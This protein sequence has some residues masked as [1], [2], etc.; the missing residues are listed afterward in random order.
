VTAPDLRVETA[1]ERFA[2]LAASLDGGIDLIEAA[3]WIAS[4]EY[5]SL[6]VARQRGRLD[7]LASTARPMLANAIHPLE[8]AQRLNSF[9]FEDQG[10]V[11]NLE[12]YDDPRNSFLNDVLE[13]RTGIPISLAAV[14]IHVAQCLDLDVRGVCFPG[15]FLVKWID[16]VRDVI[17]DPFCGEVLSEDRCQEHLAPAPRPPP[18]RSWAATRSCA[19]S[20]TSGRRATEK[21]WFACSPT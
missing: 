2:A 8:R 21:Y 16:P 5:P 4:E 11:G 6:D 15:H 14:Y 1:R 10:F 17:V 7:D 13:R 19:P 12:D 9:L 3:L 18:P 20:C